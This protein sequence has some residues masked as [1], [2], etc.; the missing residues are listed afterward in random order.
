L[1][2]MCERV[3]NGMTGFVADSSEN[4][5]TS[6]CRLLL[7]DDLWQTQHNAA[8]KLQRRWGWSEAAQEFEKLI[9]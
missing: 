5:S 7:D 9:P 4:F 2:S 8:L 3:V 1:G 6:A